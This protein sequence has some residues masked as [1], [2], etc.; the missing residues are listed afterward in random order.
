MRQLS[1]EHSALRA[2]NDSTTSLRQVVVAEGSDDYLGFFDDFT[3]SIGSFIMCELKMRTA[4]RAKALNVYPEYG[5]Y[6]V[7]A[8]TEFHEQGMQSLR[9][10]IAFFSAFVDSKPEERGIERKRA[11]R[12]GEEVVTPDSSVEREGATTVPDSDFQKRLDSHARGLRAML[13][14][15][16]VKATDAAAI[17]RQIQENHAALV[18]GGGDCSP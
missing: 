7:Q 4:D 14:D 1:R 3:D 8:A 17:D 18:R 11:V 10:A 16:E 13:V 6:A 5:E 12:T 2:F 9:S 15:V